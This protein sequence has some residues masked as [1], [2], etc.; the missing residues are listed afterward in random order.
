MSHAFADDAPFWDG[1]AESYSQK[2]VDDPDAFERKI[3]ITRSLMEPGCSVLDVGCGTGSLALILAPDAGQVHGLDL[4]PGMID[5]ARGKAEAQGVDNVHF[6]AGDLGGFD[7]FGPGEL[8]VICAYSLLHLVPDRQATLARML[9]LLRPGGAFIASTVCLSPFPYG[10]VLPVMRWLGKAPHVKIVSHDTMV[11][12]I[13]GA[14]FVE[15]ERRDVG[16]KSKLVCFVTA[17]KP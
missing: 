3:A 15:V 9:E 12:E 11:R 14:G 6:H 17:R 13:E 4:S 16:A 1:I 7:A 5:I 10:L 2:P 8:D